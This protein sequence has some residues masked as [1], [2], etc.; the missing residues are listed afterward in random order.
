MPPIALIQSSGSLLLLIEATKGEVAGAA[1]TNDSDIS[2]SVS[3]YS[4]GCCCV[5]LVGEVIGLAVFVVAEERGS[6]CDSFQTL[7]ADEFTD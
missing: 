4:V 7:L 1:G 5:S 2:C 3:L 6:S